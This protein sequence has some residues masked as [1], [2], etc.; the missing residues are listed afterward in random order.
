MISGFGLYFDRAN[1]ENCHFAFCTDKSF[2]EHARKMCLDLV[3][4]GIGRVSWVAEGYQEKYSCGG[5]KRCELSDKVKEIS[6]NY[7][8]REKHILAALWQS[9]QNHEFPQSP[10]KS[11][12]DLH[13]ESQI[14]FCPKE[15]LRR[16][17]K[18]DLQTS[19][20]LFE[21]RKDTDPVCAVHYAE[22]AFLKTLLTG[23]ETCKSEV[24]ERLN[25][26]E[27]VAEGIVRANEAAS[28]LDSKP[29]IAHIRSAQQLQ[30]ALLVQAEAVLL[31]SGHMLFSKKVA[32]GS[33]NFRKA[34][35]LYQRVQQISEALWKLNKTQF[36]KEE[37]KSIKTMESDLKN[38]LEFGE[39][40]IC[41]SLKMAP[42]S[43]GK[44][45]KAVLG[46]ES[47]KNKGLKLL[48][49]CINSKGPRA[50]LALIFVLFWL[51]I[52]IP[53]FVPGREE[54]YKE[55]QSLIR[56]ALQE[57][58][59][60]PFFIW[61][62]SYLNQKK[63][64]LQR[65]FSEL[66]KATRSLKRFE[67]PFSGRLAFEKGWLL[68]LCQDWQNAI[69]EFE[70]AAQNG[71]NSCFVMLLL[72]VSYCMSGELRSAEAILQEVEKATV[73]SNDKWIIRR[74]QS[75]LKRRWFQLFPFEIMYVSDYIQGMKL[76]WY[77]RVDEFLKEF[78]VDEGEEKALFLLLRGA[79]LRNAGNLKGSLDCLT[80]SLE[81]E[82]ELTSEIWVVPHA[83]YET[84][85]VYVK[86]RDWE[87][88]LH[89]LKTAK[90]YKGK[91]DFRRALNFK[92][93]AIHEYIKQEQLKER[94]R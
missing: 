19:E 1:Q 37:L 35:K 48:Y 2:E 83:Y 28:V 58:P 62:S 70:V 41:L 56:F 74:A 87:S 32:S 77:E 5:C 79:V 13:K 43:M 63:G 22:A 8:G 53:E 46:I 34:W 73:E 94:K 64:N 6:L 80:E 12:S 61:L 29:T 17:W 85:M 67:L 57:F 90:S 92:L 27:R 38:F 14:D 50:P 72:G 15:A 11:N 9:F 36:S 76:E 16:M 47:D 18:G 59:S 86:S 7:P 10:V 81:L 31:K 44:L 82:P 4:R 3:R 49:S 84:A 33:M 25:Y 52:Y 54:R 91:F 69:N 40:V 89:F 45:S 93:N 26:S 24:L 21:E 23:N 66:H 39:G 78:E 68:F 88:A 55:S 20:A 42:E 51:L 65:A 60:S 30:L 71:V 75:F